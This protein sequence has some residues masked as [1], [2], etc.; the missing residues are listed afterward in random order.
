MRTRRPRR[1]HCRSISGFAPGAPS[2]AAA[3]CCGAGDSAGVVAGGA[4]ASD[5]AVPWVRFGAGAVQE[6]VPAGV[7]AM[8]AVMGLDAAGVADACREAGEGQVVEPVN[9]N[10][11][12]QIVIAG[13]RG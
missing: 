7:G 13:H 9:F 2:P 6:A 1:S 10:A 5:A 11:P 12:D 8:A 4:L 3:C